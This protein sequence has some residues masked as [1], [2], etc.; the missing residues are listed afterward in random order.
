MSG[1]PSSSVSAALAK[2]GIFATSSL[3]SNNEPE[4]VS[5]EKVLMSMTLATSS[6]TL[7][8]N[9]VCA[10]VISSVA[11]AEVGSTVLSANKLTILV[12]LETTA[13]MASAVTLDAG[14][15]LCMV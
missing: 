14:S 3:P 5:S 15:T 10:A 9:V 2:T 13:L 6:A 11:V 12:T 1:I 8:N 4:S 7:D